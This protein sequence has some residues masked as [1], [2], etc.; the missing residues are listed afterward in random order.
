LHQVL[1]F[2]IMYNYANH[3]NSYHVVY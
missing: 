2:T 3:Y 1:E